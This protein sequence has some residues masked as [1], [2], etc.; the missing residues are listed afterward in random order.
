MLI[1]PVYLGFFHSNKSNNNTE[2]LK[3]IYGYNILNEIINNDN[4]IIIIKKSS[5]CHSSYHLSK[6]AKTQ[7]HLNPLRL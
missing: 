3:T 6:S 4:S 2:P 7:E 1:C 5:K